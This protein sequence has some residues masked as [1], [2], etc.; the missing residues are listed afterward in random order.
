MPGYLDQYGAGDEQRIRKIRKIVI[1]VVSIAIAATILFFMFRNFREEQRG[2]Q[3][4]ALLNAKDYKAAYAMF[5]CTDAKPCS[6][7]SFDMFMADWGPGSGHNL[8][9]ARITGSRSC[10]SGVLL[11]VNYGSGQEKLWV[12]RKDMTVGFPPFQVCP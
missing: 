12:E 7:Y 10:G 8:A 9:A 6:A 2:K 5:G 11:T 3:F 1:S 4:L